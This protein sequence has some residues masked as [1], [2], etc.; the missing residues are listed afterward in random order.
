MTEPFSVIQIK[1][2]HK[3]KIRCFILAGQSNMSG[4]GSLLNYIN[5]I[6]STIYLFGNDYKWHYAQ[7]PT[8]NENGQV[9]QCSKDKHP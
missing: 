8:D 3:G 7:E 2:E 5:E 4:R 9:D 6:D 1:Q